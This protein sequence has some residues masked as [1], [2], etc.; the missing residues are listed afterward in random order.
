MSRYAWRGLGRAFRK[1]T[2][3]AGKSRGARLAA[4]RTAGPSPWASTIRFASSAVIAGTPLRSCGNAAAHG[5]E[6]WPRSCRGGAWGTCGGLPVRGARWP[7]PRPAL[8]PR[9]G[10][11]ASPPLACRASPPERCCWCH[12][13]SPRRARPRP[14]PRAPRGPRCARGLATTALVPGRAVGERLGASRGRL[15][16]HA[17]APPALVGEGRSGLGG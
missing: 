12:P 4:S 5:V 15:A 6:R 3:S 14:G 17:K 11:R 1:V 7:D 2:A 16:P 8:G 10:P 9:Q 13:R